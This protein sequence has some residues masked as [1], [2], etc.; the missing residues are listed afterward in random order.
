MG[1]LPTLTQANDTFRFD[2]FM[3]PGQ[4]TRRTRAVSLYPTEERQI[5]NVH[6][7]D[8]RKETSADGRKSLFRNKVLVDIFNYWKAK[9]KAPQNEEASAAAI[10][11]SQLTLPRTT[12]FEWRTEAL[13]M[14]YQQLAAI[15]DSESGFWATKSHR[16]RSGAADSERRYLQRAQSDSGCRRPR[17]ISARVLSATQQGF[18]SCH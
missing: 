16:Q 5:L 3:P 17:P 14:G 2:N 7:E 1:C 9:G 15:H 6:R 11:V 13:G 12:C 10:K 18:D 8:F 4:R